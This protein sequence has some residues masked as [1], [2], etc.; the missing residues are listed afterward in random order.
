M[1][2]EA[3]KIKLGSALHEKDEQAMEVEGRCLLTQRPIR[4]TVTG[5]EIRAAI[6]PVVQ[7]IAQG[8]LNALTDLTPT[9]AG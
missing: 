5:A 4:T 9:V 3:V 7:K 1:T 6:E 8:V 2:A